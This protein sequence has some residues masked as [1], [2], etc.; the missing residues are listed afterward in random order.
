METPWK[1]RWRL[2]WILLL[3][4]SFAV[5]G[6]HAKKKSEPAP[7]AKKQ[8]TFTHVKTTAHSKNMV[9]VP[10]LLG[11]SRTEAIRIIKK[12]GLKMG[13]INTVKKGKGKPDTIVRQS[14]KAKTKT[15]QGSKVDLWMLKPAASVH[16]TKNTSSRTTKPV[17]TV[18]RK[19]TC[20]WCISNTLK[21]RPVTHARQCEK[22][23]GQ[24]FSSKSEALRKLQVLKK[25]KQMKAAK[26]PS[27]G[28]GRRPISPASPPINDRDRRKP[29]PDGH[30]APAQGRLPDSAVNPTQD[31]SGARAANPL[32]PEWPARITAITGEKRPGYSITIRGIDFGDETGQVKIAS[33][34]AHPE[35]IMSAEIVSWR[36]N[37]IVCKIPRSFAPVAGSSLLPSIVRVWPAPVEPADTSTTVSLTG[38]KPYPYSGT[39]GPAVKFDMEPLIPV[40]Y[41]LSK[42]T[43]PEG[44]FFNI[45]GRDLNYFGYGVTG[46][47]IHISHNGDRIPV[48]IRR[49]RTSSI[50]LRVLNMRIPEFDGPP[51]TDSLDCRL[52]VVNNLSNESLPYNLTV[53]R[54]DDADLVVDH[55][56]LKTWKWKSGELKSGRIVVAVR[57]RGNETRWDPIRV[58][59][60]N[61]T[62]LNYEIVIEP[63]PRGLDPG[64]VAKSHEFEFNFN[65]SHYIGVA[66]LSEN[67]IPS[68]DGCELS[69]ERTGVGR[70]P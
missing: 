61:H 12:L 28:K 62:R 26:S 65:G 16:K 20:K 52:T 2:I 34:P 31:T 5:S 70:C 29:N 4:L 8:T 24:C 44:E 36:H 9:V 66:I 25:Q 7:G 1:N 47:E 33:M 57:N 23:Q 59:V 18:S 37:M 40:I 46:R 15:G 43:V 11:K 22:T 35:G 64:P 56:D 27:A 6:V 32:E 13:R 38:E 10:N 54:Y 50:R 51:G 42:T 68:N 63:G 60:R 67:A 39:E 17:K 41:S 19:K 3:V 49:W 21:L 14:P 45:Q 30:T 48:E 53:E 55:V 69:L 58:L